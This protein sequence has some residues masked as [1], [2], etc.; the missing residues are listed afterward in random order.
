MHVE[1]ATG[2]AKFWLGP[3]IL[4]ARNEGLSPRR[5]A[6]AL[7]WYEAAGVGCVELKIKSFLD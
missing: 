5:L 6:S 1:H 2:K 7:H 4:V 3:K